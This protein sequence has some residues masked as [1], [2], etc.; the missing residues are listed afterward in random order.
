MQAVVRV[1][2]AMP[3]V[4]PS[5]E[6]KVGNRLFAASLAVATLIGLSACSTP[7]AQLTYTALPKEGDEGAGFPFVV[8]RTV[9]KVTPTADKSGA[10]ERVAFVAVPLAI[11]QG[12]KS[13]LPTFVAIDSSSRG[14]A[15]T[16]TTVGSITYLDD[17]IVSAIGTQVTDNRKDAVTAVVTAAS[18]ASSFA[19]A[20]KVPNCASDIVP[21]KSFVV[22]DFS[23][24]AELPVPNAK[25]WAYRLV[26][27]PVKLIGRRAYPV[28]GLESVKDANW[29]PVPACKA[30]SIRVFHCANDDCTS[31][32]KDI[33]SYETTISLSAGTH[34]QRIP[35]SAKGKVSL[36]T[37]YC[38]ADVTNENVVASD[39]SLLKQLLSDVKSSIK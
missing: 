30:Y 10:T 23:G 12:G 33:Q 17:L 4:L 36:H 2:L 3:S 16:P 39:W 25:C 13:Q 26:E 35:L 7:Q 32:R 28:A 27:A 19:S 9:L 8:P 20:S 15:L 38:G 21:L 5:K 34:Y 31:E 18:L 11:A 37:D 6:F 14:F 1:S 22:S 29:F 24:P